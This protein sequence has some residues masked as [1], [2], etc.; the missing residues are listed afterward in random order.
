MDNFLHVPP[1]SIE[2]VVESL[3]EE[4]FDWVARYSITPEFQKKGK[5]E[6]FPCR[7]GAAVG[8]RKADMISVT[9]KIL[10]KDLP[11]YWEE[12]CHYGNY[13][14]YKCVTALQQQKDTCDT[15]EE[16]SFAGAVH[17]GACV[18]YLPEW[19][20]WVSVAFSGFKSNKDKKIAKAALKE[21]FKAKK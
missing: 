20:S 21:F 18:I 4:I 14:S 5:G 7:G 3:A 1:K 6:K 12:D 8:Y 15:G 16:F 10:N 11:D 9:S 17:A 2:R 19:E 13:A